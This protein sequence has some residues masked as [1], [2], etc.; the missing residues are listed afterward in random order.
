MHSDSV[1]SIE[2]DCQEW[3]DGARGGIQGGKQ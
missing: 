1:Q 2:E 3:C